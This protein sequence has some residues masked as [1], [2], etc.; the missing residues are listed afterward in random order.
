MKM[1]IKEEKEGEREINRREK[2]M[3]GIFF[4]DDIRDR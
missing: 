1:K 2:R 4:F 3:R